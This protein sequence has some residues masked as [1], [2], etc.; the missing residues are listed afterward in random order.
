MDY[1]SLY[2]N[3][4]CDGLWAFTFTLFGV[5]ILLLLVGSN[6]DDAVKASREE[7]A[8][9]QLTFGN[10]AVLVLAL[11]FLASGYFVKSLQNGSITEL[12]NTT[13]SVCGD[14]LNSVIH[15]VKYLSKRYDNKLESFKFMYGNNIISK[16]QYVNDILNE[17]YSTGSS[18]SPDYS[19]EFKDATVNLKKGM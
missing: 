8:F 14:T 6:I 19:A 13:V 5:V 15:N 16:E 2:N 4:N 10:M 17:F 18:G 7:S 12:N 11:G 3:Y 1:F 9:N